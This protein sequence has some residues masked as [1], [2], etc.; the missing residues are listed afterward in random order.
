MFTIVSSCIQRYALVKFMVQM[1][2]DPSFFHSFFPVLPSQ[3]KTALILRGDFNLVFNTGLDRLNKAGSYHNWQTT[4]QIKQYME[5]KQ[6]C[7]VICYVH[8][9]TPHS[10]SQD[11]LS[12]SVGSHIYPSSF[13]LLSNLALVIYSPLLPISCPGTGLR[14]CAQGCVCAC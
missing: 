7:E 13:C 14:K 6:S 8:N 4:D 9:A 3:S 1:F 11:N 5:K 2:D 12:V 10:G